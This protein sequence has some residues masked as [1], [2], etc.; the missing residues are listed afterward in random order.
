[1][2]VEQTSIGLFYVGIFLHSPICSGRRPRPIYESTEISNYIN[3]MSL[4]G[5]GV[6]YT[7]KKFISW[8]ELLTQYKQTIVQNFFAVL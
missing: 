7:A 8:S 1:M 4:H 3:L 2:S 6:R 5:K